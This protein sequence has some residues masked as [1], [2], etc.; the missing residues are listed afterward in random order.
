MTTGVKP[1]FYT[2]QNNTFIFA[3]EIKAILKFPGVEK[4][5]DSQGISELFGIGP[6]HTSGT[7]VFKNIFE[8]KPAHFGVFN[9]SGLHLTKYWSLKSKEHTDSLGKTCEKIRYLLND[10]IT[11][12]L[13]SDKPICT[14]LSG[15]FNFKYNNKICC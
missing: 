3:S 11:S 5:I 8:L 4:I 14:F 12:Q 9:K 1:F 7:T 10:S 6:S 15:G 13:V 2:I